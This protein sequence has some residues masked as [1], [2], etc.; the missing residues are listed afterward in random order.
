LTK[1]PD[2]KAGNQASVDF[3]QGIDAY[4]A[5]KYRQAIERFNQAI[6]EVSSFPEAYHNRGLAF[7]NL[8][9]DDEAVVNLITASELYHAQ[10]QG[11]AITIIKQNLEAL[12]KRKIEREN[13]YQK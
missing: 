9:S 2:T 5:G 10:D 1:L 3:Q 8:R 13:R 4:N 7:A 6:Q 12:K 11:E